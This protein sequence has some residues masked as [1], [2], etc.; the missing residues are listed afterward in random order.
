MHINFTYS[1]KYLVYLTSHAT[2]FLQ[3]TILNQN[4]TKVMPYKEALDFCKN[5]FNTSPGFRACSQL[6]ILQHDKYIADCAIDVEVRR[7]H[8]YVDVLSLDFFIRPNNIYYP[9]TVYKLFFKQKRIS[10]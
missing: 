4:T 10:D 9:F 3:R 2:I 5:V 6:S 7:M 1:N 8:K